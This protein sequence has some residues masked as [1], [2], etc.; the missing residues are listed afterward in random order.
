MSEGAQGKAEGRRSQGI[1][2][3]S[4]AS[5]FVADQILALIR[6]DRLGPESHLST[7]RLAS[8]F[9]VSRWPVEQALKELAR[10]GFV[11]H[12][13]HRG[14]FVGS[15][16]APAGDLSP[17]PDAVQE[18]YLAIADDLIQGRIAR[19]ISESFVRERYRLGRGQAVALFARLSREGLASRRLGYGWNFS[20]ILTTPEAL[21]HSYQLRLMIEPASLL[22][23]GYSLSADEISR[24]R[25]VEEDLLAGGIERLSP[26][27]L[28][29][30]AVQ[31]HEVL[32]S[33]TGNPFLLETMR[34]VNRVRRL[35]TYQSMTDRKRYFRQ[36]QE[37]LALLDH[38]EASR[39]EEAAQAMRDHLGGVM[40]QMRGIGLLADDRESAVPKV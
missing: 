20:E 24:L 25:A 33:G 1:E 2:A 29:D 4:G 18:A 10:K 15:G 6:D 26:D 14:F 3:R 35:L 31:F 23:K 30:R 19:Q 40:V 37:H 17:Q 34:R 11:I 21:E 28:F 8:R 9:G 36:S 39:F 7:E 22:Q 5:S 38:I 32:I 12:R 27:A 13:P 16:A